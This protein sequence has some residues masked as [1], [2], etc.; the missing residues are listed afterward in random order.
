MKQQQK[1]LDH[2]NLFHSVQASEEPGAQ[3]AKQVRRLLGS[4]GELAMR[5]YIEIRST[6]DPLKPFLIHPKI[7]QNHVMGEASFKDSWHPPLQKISYQ[8]ILQIY[9]H[10]YTNFMEAPGKSKT[11]YQNLPWVEFRCETWA[12]GKSGPQAKSVQ[13]T[14]ISAKMRDHTFFKLTVQ[15]Q[16]SGTSRLVSTTRSIW[17]SESCGVAC[18]TRFDSWVREMHPKLFDWTRNVRVLCN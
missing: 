16:K 9:L 1:H 5:K 18:V 7:K 11:F 8:F 4:T 10:S 6:I 13:A 14:F 2:S 3:T 17:K 12:T 15:W